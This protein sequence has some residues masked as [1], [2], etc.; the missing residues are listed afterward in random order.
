MINAALVL[1]G[2]S[3]RSLYTA[4]VLDVLIENGLEFSCV[5]GA[6]AGALCGANYISKQSG[7]SAKMNI[8]QSNDSGYFGLK[9]Y[10]FKKD[11]FNYDYLFDKMHELF[12]YK[13][14]AIATTEQKF[15]IS[16]TSCDTGLVEYFNP[17]NYEDMIH[18]LKASSS[19]PTFSRQVEIDGRC[20]IDG[21]VADSIGIEK[22]IEEGYKKM[23]VVLT[24][25]KDFVAKELAGSKKGRVKRVYKKHPNLVSALLS[26]PARYNAT[27]KK[28][29]LLESEGSAFVFRPKTQVKVKSLE[30]DARKLFSLYMQGRD[31]GL[32]MLDNLKEF[33]DLF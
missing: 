2:G 32:E 30:R 17:K 12:P 11:I 9:Q 6:S 24:R 20:Y 23:V 27:T 1:E 21:A 13:K 15:L 7:R 19:I 26:R 3:L 33:L 8:L 22:A 14:E 5:I 28:L 31:D 10:L 29:Q 18:F 25:D 4:G 16:A